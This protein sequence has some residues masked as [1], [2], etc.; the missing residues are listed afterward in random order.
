VSKGSATRLEQ[1]AATKTALIAAATARFGAD[2][3]QATTL[4]VAAADVG[5]TKGA[6]YHHFAGKKA[7]FT[8]VFMTVQ[9][10]LVAAVAR[11]SATGTALERLRNACRC[12]LDECTAGTAR[13]VLADGPSV[14][15]DTWYQ[16]EDRLWLRALRD[17][18]HHAQRDGQFAP[19]DT[20]L[21][22]RVISAAITQ[23]ATAAIDQSP[24]A[25]DVQLVLLAT[26]RGFELPG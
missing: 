3:Y 23:L 1:A 25:P 14:L 5:V 9:R 13:I 21:A 22:A 6:V 2:G 11:S 24:S 15:G 4:D 20:D 12:Y 16:I 18:I 8:A 26:L 7:L 17:L 10:G 19:V